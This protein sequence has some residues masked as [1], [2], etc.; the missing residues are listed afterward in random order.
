[1]VALLITAR[2]KKHVWGVWCMSKDD[3]QIAI[4]FGNISV[5]ITS[6]VV[7]DKHQNFI[8]GK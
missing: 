1:M 5:E 2:R 8:K 4:Y 3:E 7:P 6:S